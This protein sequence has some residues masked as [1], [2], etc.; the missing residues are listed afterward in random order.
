VFRSPVRRLTALLAAALLLF[1]V[2]GEALGLHA[3]PHHSYIEGAAPG[4]P[5]PEAASGHGA[6]GAAHAEHPAAPATD[7]AGD[8]AEHADHG[9]CTCLGGCPPLGAA[10]L[11]GAGGQAAVPV[12]GD[13]VRVR[14]GAE[15]A[16]AGPIPFV[17]PYG[18]APPAA[19]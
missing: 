19:A 3:C 14:P 12:P 17:L 11:P 4:A 10:V 13:V 2:T 1:T 18:H 9:T 15:R 8:P 16:S 7:A 6:H 5:V